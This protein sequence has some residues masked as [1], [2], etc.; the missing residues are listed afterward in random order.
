ME[1]KDFIKTC[2]TL[3]IGGMIL[4][5]GAAGCTTA[6]Y[7]AKS[8]IANNILTIKK[9]EFII[10]DKDK[11]ILR[12]FILVKSDKLNFPVCIYKIKDDQYTALFMQ[13]THQGCELQPNA[14]YLV[15][16]CHGSEFNNLGIVQNPPAETNLKSFKITTD[17]ENLYIQL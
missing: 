7:F 9:S 17:S 11:I 5:I 6:N 15:C 13:C 8:T 2:S 1:R 12:K 10:A 4:G 16:P 14:K 3:C